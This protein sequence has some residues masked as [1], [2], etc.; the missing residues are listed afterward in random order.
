MPLRLSQALRSTQTLQS[1]C[2]VHPK[3]LLS[4]YSFPQLHSW[5]ASRCTEPEKLELKS[6][7]DTSFSLL[8]NISFVAEHYH[9]WFR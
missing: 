3:Y 8:I 9:Y 4:Q 6:F 7:Q 1:P 5:S 2:F